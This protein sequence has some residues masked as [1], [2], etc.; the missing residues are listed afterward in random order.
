M[1]REKVAAAVGGACESGNGVCC[2]F[3]LEYRSFLLGE[4]SKIW[5]V[6]RKLLRSS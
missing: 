5:G 1:T 4:A 2:V 6:G 3:Y